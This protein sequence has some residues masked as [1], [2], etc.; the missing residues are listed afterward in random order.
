MINNEQDRIIVSLTINLVRN[1]GLSVVA[2]GVEEE[3][4][5]TTLVDMGCKLLQGYHIAKPMAMDMFDACLSKNGAA[6]KLKGSVTNEND[7]G[8]SPTPF[9]A[10]TIEIRDFLLVPLGNDRPVLPIAR[11]MFR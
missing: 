5:A 9:F 7:C 3:N 1:M 11:N 4:T 6:L 2:K 10:Y 8:L